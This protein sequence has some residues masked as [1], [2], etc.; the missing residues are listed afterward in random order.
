MKHPILSFEPFFTWGWRSKI[1]YKPG[2]RE[3][4]DFEM[5][6]L[7]GT[8]VF[9][10]TDKGLVQADV[11]EMVIETIKASRLE[12]VGFYD[13][14]VQ[15][16]RIDLINEGAALYRKCG[17]DCM[18]SVGGGSVMDTAKA[19]NILIGK[20]L[21][22]FSPLADQVGLFEDAEPLPPHIAFPTTAGTGAEV[23]YGMVVLGDITKGKITC[24]HPYCSPDIAML[25]PELTVNLPPKITAFTAMDAMTHAIEAVINGSANPISDSLGLHAIRIIMTYLPEVMKN[26]D[27]VEARGYLLLAS[28]MAGISMANALLGAVHSTAHALGALYGIPHGLANSIMLPHVMTFNLEE[29]PTRFIFIADAMGVKID[30]MTA[31]QAARAAVEAL[32]DLQ[33]SVGLTETLKDFGVPDDREALQ[34]LIDLAM[35]DA[36]TPY[37]PRYLEE[38]DVYDLYLK[39][40]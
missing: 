10:C 12:L 11:A 25:D 3:E 24:G 31:E 6:N 20:G 2:A 1:M 40:R 21:D 5:E 33:K 8:K 19:I 32:K 26:A 29:D 34:P 28:S 15:D 18:V 16:A 4:L 36:Q 23:S 38:D 30:D 7:G 9:L 13:K 35:G 17:A 22:D 27:N 14:I 37:N 39:A